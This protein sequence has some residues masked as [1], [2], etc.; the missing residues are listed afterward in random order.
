MPTMVIFSSRED[1]S[2]ERLTTA[3]AITIAL[4][5]GAECSLTTNIK[6]HM[7]LKRVFELET[8]ALASSAIQGSPHDPIWTDS[9]SLA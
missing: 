9:I 7:H 2:R 4:R 5:S 8:V 6:E 1:C 3:V